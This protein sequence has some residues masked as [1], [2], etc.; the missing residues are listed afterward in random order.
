M[1]LFIV[2]IQLHHL[3]VV[4]VE[5]YQ[6]DVSTIQGLLSH[7]AIWLIENWKTLLLQLNQYW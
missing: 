2:M 4:A 3:F 1:P 6:Y 7:C 5:L